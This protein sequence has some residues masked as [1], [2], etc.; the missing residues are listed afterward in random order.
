MTIQEGSMP[1]SKAKIAIVYYSKTGHSRHAAER[2]ALALDAD[3]FALHTPRYTFPFFGYL[4]A[5]LDSLRRT[6]SSLPRPLPDIKNHAAVIICGPIWTSYPAVPLIS[7]MQQAPQL[8]Q[9]V[10]LMLTCGS[11]SSPEKAYARAETELG[12]SFVTMATISNGIEDQP[13]AET[14]IAEFAKAMEDALPSV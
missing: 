9:L 2:L 12:R 10:G 5:G 4:R 7:Y 8:P 6:P 14:K 11:Q 13:E 3:L 1:A